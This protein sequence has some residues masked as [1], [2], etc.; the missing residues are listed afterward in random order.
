MQ[1]SVEAMELAMRVLRAVN[2]KRNP[3][4]ADL[5]ALRSLA[6]L[7]ANLPPDELACD[8]IRQALEHRAKA[9]AEAR[10]RT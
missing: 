3:D 9:R 10:M 6:P 5:S 7:V 1:K 8:V 4:E 2:E